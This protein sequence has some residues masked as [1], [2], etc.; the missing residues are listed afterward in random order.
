[1]S[2]TANKLKASALRKLVDFDP[3]AATAVVATLFPGAAEKGL[4]LAKYAFQAYLVGVIR[5]I[6]TGAVTLIEIVT[7]DAADMTGHVTVIASRSATPADAVGDTVWLE[8]TGEEVGALKAATNLYLGVR[9]TLATSTDE[10][11]LYF[12]AGR[13]RAQDGL[14]A[15]YVS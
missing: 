6:G 11:V 5:T 10:C 1:M 14:T 15:D 9:V 3:D 4:A 2:Y 12:E 8:C 7:A 13:G